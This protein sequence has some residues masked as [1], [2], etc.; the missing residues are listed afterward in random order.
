ME[1]MKMETEIRTQH[2]G[3]VVAIEISE[4]DSVTAGQAIIQLG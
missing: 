1:A 2:A 3:T 4:G